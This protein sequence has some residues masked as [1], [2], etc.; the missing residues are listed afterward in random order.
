MGAPYTVYFGLTIF[1][2][3][4]DAYTSVPDTVRIK[5]LE[6]F[7][8]WKM[9]PNTGQPLFASEPMKKL[10]SFLTRAKQQ[11]NERMMEDNRRRQAEMQLRVEQFQ[12]NGPMPQSALLVEVDKLIGMTTQRRELDRSDTD[13]QEQLAVLNKLRTL[14]ASQTLP[15][16]MLPTIQQ[17]LV[18]FNKKEAEI[19]SKKVQSLSSR[20]STPVSATST[21]PPVLP[22]D[23]RGT[24]NSAGQQYRLPPGG[25]AAAQRPAP[26]TGP[27]AMVGAQMPQV[28]QVPQMPQMPQNF[29]GAAAPAIPQ[30]PQLAQIAQIAQQAQQMQGVVPPV[31][32]QAVLDGLRHVREG[33]PATVR[34]ELTSASLS[35]ARPE[36]VRRLYDAMPQQCGTCGKRFTGDPKGYRERE[37]HMD[38]HVRVNKRLMDATRTQSRSWFIPL[39]DWVEFKD[40]EDILGLVSYSKP[41]AQAEVPK[42]STE[43][44]MKK[45]VRVPSEPS[46]AKSPCPICQEQF[47]TTWNDDIEEWVY[48]NAVEVGGRIFHA[49]CYSES[50]QG[51]KGGDLIKRLTKSSSRSTPPREGSPLISDL[52]NLKNILKN[53]KKHNHKRKANDYDGPPD[54]KKFKV[55]LDY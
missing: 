49:T 18:T 5:M 48:R 29:Y 20:E 47:E 15:Q 10:D 31:I 26:P 42:E 35:V 53:T 55:E 3:F 34:I 7:Q 28:P 51:G 44:L 4:A 32:S 39:E 6:L 25:P 22:G 11:L 50:N 13:A 36:L 21:P 9:M 41:A 43:D 45:Y 1:K 52:D 23:P 37:M 33:S 17:Q 14:L 2:V 16:Q 19:L 30:L 40:E 46:K 54:E 24:G 38:W 12:Q 27:A 8:T